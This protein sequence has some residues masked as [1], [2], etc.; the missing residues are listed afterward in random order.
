M[1]TKNI[2]S[3]NAESVQAICMANSL[4]NQ[5]YCVVGFLQNIGMVAF[6]IEKM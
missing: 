5:G 1:N 3:I 6:S 4:N 2:L